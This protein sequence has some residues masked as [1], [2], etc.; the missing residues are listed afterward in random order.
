MVLH[1]PRA[2]VANCLNGKSSTKFHVRFCACFSPGRIQFITPI[3]L[4]D[5][6]WPVP[7]VLS[8][9]SGYLFSL[10]DPGL[11][12]AMLR[13]NRSRILEQEFGQTLDSHAAVCSRAKLLFFCTQAGASKAQ[14][15]LG[16]KTIFNVFSSCKQYYL[17][18]LMINYFFPICSKEDKCRSWKWSKTVPS[19]CTS[20]SQHCKCTPH[21][22]RAHLGK[23]TKS[24]SQPSYNK[25]QQI[26][27][28]Q[29][30]KPHHVLYYYRT[31][32]VSHSLSSWT[33]RFLLHEQFPPHSPFL[34]SYSQRTPC[35][36][37]HNHWTEIQPSTYPS[38]ISHFFISCEQSWPAFNPSESEP[39]SCL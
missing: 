10:N 32:L 24:S 7:L 31:F 19:E 37:H 33:L 3:Y 34:E 29:N 38:T 1:I 21:K 35:A 16:Q 27:A 8:M 4:T 12:Q 13:K 20:C 18:S 11:E 9:H 39:P 26:W 22:L 25:T 5:R 30:K 17:Q 23:V 15:C 36:Q 6:P 2:E 28:K 14:S